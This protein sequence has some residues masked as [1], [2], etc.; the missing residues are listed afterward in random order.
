[1]RKWIVLLLGLFIVSCTPYTAVSQPAPLPTPIPLPPT[2]DAIWIDASYM[3]EDLGISVREAVRRGM[4]QDR[5]G[6]L[7][8]MLEENEAD[9]FAGL[10]IEHEP[11]YQV[12]AAFTENGERTLRPY[13]QT[14]PIPAEVTV[15]EFAHSLTELRELQTAVNN[16]L[17]LLQ[18]PHSSS[19]NVKENN[20]E[21]LISDEALLHEKLQAAGE[22]LPE[23]VVVTVTYVP[24]A[25]PLP[26]TAV[27]DVLMP[28][29]N[30]RS[31]SFMEALAI[32]T[33][34]VVNG[35]LRIVGDHDSHLIIWQ[36]D[37][38]LNNNNGTLEIWNRDGEA[39]AIV[40]EA[41]AMGGG[42]GPMPQNHILQDPL[43]E[44]CT[45]PYWYMGE[46]VGEN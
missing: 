26:V 28:Q 43:P 37:Y 19:I 34:E 13:L 16:Q 44:T 4:V 15:L 6:Q 41:I 10:W 20:V 7:N 38:F 29:L 24:L 8:A 33:L 36:T 31:T 35:C 14:Y 21:I 30:M 39:V 11:S 17:S 42:E 46:I 27:S 5:I 9:T 22:T 45:G 23:D 32:G 3:A 2:T 25:E 18:Y 12:V 40:G 1:M